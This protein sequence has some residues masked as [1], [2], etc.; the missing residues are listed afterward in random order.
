M[1]RWDLLEVEIQEHKH[2]ENSLTLL[3]KV[4]TVFHEIPNH[5]ILVMEMLYYSKID[6]YMGMS[7]KE[8]TR[9]SLYNFIKCP[10]H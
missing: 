1:P 10:N 2:Y 7:H 3:N 4:L 6:Y 8:L 9:M 5:G